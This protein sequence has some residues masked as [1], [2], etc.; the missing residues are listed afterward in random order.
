VSTLIS[1]YAQR[2]A[3]LLAAPAGAT[4]IG[5]IQAGAGAVARTL[6]ARSRETVNAAD[7][8]F[9]SAA[10]AAVNAAALQAAVD[11]LAAS[12]GLVKISRSAVAYQFDTGILIPDG[13]GITGDGMWNTLLRYTGVGTGLMAKTVAD[14]T[15]KTALS[16]FTLQL[17]GI[18]ARGIDYSRWMYSHFDDIRI[19]N[20]AGNTQTGLR[21][22]ISNVAWTCYQNHFGRIVLDGLDTGW[23]VD[24][25]VAQYANRTHVVN[26]VFTNCAKGFNVQAVQG[27]VVAKQQHNEQTGVGV[28]LGA[29]V[30]RIA[31][32]VTEQETNSGG[33]LWSIDP[34]ANR[35]TEGAQIIHAGAD[36]SGAGIGKRAFRVLD[37]DDGIQW[38]GATT[39]TM[40]AKL[41]ADDDTGLKGTGIRS[42][43]GLG[44]AAVTVSGWAGKSVALVYGVSVAIDASQGRDFTATANNATAFAIAAPTNATTGQRITVMVRNTSGGALGAVTWNAVF[45]LAAWTSPANGFS[46]SIDFRFDGTNWVEVGRTTV[47]VPN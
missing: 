6:Q 14:E 21:A 42:L 7:F 1:R 36:G 11:S 15:C 5:F 13:V 31:F 32:G 44:T 47:D 45:K 30:D 43:A 20:Q 25:T 3:A 9:D 18:G 29:G 26:V 4:L 40:M 22:V 23:Y 41:Y 34:A 17:A 8:G 28:T 35:V 24:S 37:W 38:S 12:G 39:A 33:S 2:F 27:M 10:S 19:A 16:K 46:R